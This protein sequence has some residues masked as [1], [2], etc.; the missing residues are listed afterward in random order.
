MLSATHCKSIVGV[1]FFKPVF[2]FLDHSRCSR[3]CPA[4]TDEL[5]LEAGI[6]RCLGLFQS[7]RDFLQDLAERHDTEILLSTFFES[8]KSKRRLALIGDILTQSQTHMRRAM[9]DPL[10]AFKCLNDF[11]IYAGDGHFIAAASHDKAAPR[12]SSAKNKT[13]GRVAT[14]TATKY[15]T[16]HLY[17]LDLRSH[18]MTHLTV[19]DQ[20]K[21]KKEHD[22]RALKRQDIQTLRQGAGKGAKSSTSGTALASTFIN[23]LSGG[24][25]ASTS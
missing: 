19:S 16:G 3:N 12:K 17:T 22:M 24:S 9:P 13:A 14:F 23:G 11:D 7:G 15:A 1:E 5:W 6:R 20:V 4:L 8:L 21:R 2:T 10:A 25:A 18:C